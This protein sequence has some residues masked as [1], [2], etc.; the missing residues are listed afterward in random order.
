MHF[1]SKDE[2]KN[3]W[4]CFKEGEFDFTADDSVGTVAIEIYKKLFKVSKTFEDFFEAISK[5]DYPA[6]KLTP[7]EMEVLNGGDIVGG[8]KICYYKAP[9]GRRMGY[10]CR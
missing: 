4:E 2:V 6:L 8:A 7:K 9:N 10:Y 5:G 1:T 3:L